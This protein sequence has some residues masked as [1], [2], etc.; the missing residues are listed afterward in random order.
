MDL[1]NGHF[2]V[3]SSGF[4]SANDDNFESCTGHKSREFK[5]YR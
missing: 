1:A 5:R 3:I 2:I 4:D